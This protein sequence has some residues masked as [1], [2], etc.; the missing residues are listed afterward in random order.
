R[1]PC[2]MRQAPRRGGADPRI[3]ARV[4]VRRTTLRGAPRRASVAACRPP[5][6]RQGDNGRVDELPNARLSIGM[7]AEVRPDRHTAGFELVVDGTPQ[8]HVD[9]DDPTHLFYEYIT[10][11]GHVIDQ[12]R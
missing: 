12:L 4:V 3:R 6:R 5:E 9:L 1:P 8:S 10:R 2:D 11:M 7:R